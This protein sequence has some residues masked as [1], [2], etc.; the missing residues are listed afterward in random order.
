M[1]R[2]TA[3]K[4]TICYVYNKRL[5]WVLHSKLKILESC[6]SPLPDSRLTQVEDTEQTRGKKT[7]DKQRWVL[8]CWFISW[9]ICLQLLYLQLNVS[10]CNICLEILL[11]SM[12]SPSL[13]CK[14]QDVPQYFSLA[15]FLNLWWHIILIS[16]LS[17]VNL[18]HIAP[19]RLLCLHSIL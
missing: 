14:F 4:A 19:F 6:P 9:C 8:H 7:H 10:S 12:L 18:W 2:R 16:W 17:T 3:A 5:E 1:W 15:C 13:K 11:G